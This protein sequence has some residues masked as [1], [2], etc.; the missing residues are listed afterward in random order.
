MKATKPDASAQSA[1]PAQ[2]GQRQ[3]VRC[4]VRFPLALPVVLST[5]KS[6]LTALTK[7]VSASGVL[8]ALDEELQVGLDIRFSLRMPGNVLGTPNDVLVHCRGRVVR[9]SLSHHQYL[10]ASTIDEYQFAEQ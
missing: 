9:C 1:V 3:E 7:N 8:F 10:T 4:A 6:E 5:G 2:P